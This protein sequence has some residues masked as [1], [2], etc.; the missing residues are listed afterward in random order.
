MA[1]PRG[2][3]PRRLRL[4]AHFAVPKPNL[5]FSRTTDT[6]SQGDPPLP[7]V[8]RTGKHERWRWSA[9]EAVGRRRWKGRRRRRL[10]GWIVGGE[11]AAAAAGGGGAPGEPAWLRALHRRR[12]PAWLAPHLL[13]RELSLALAPCI[14]LQLL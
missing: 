4:G 2:K 5:G 1:R 6:G 11:G 9:A 3:I 12:P 7:R 10:E 13:P 14:S 8:R